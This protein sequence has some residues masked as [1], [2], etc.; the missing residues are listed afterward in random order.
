M[1]HRLEHVLLLMPQMQ[2]VLLYGI[3]FQAPVADTQV[4][5][6]DRRLVHSQLSRTSH[7]SDGFYVTVLILIDL[8]D[9]R[10]G[11]DKAYREPQKQLLPVRDLPVQQRPAHAF[12]Q[13]RQRVA[14]DHPFPVGRGDPLRHVIEDPGQVEQHPQRDVHHVGQVLH[15]HAV[16]QKPAGAPEGEGQERGRRRHRVQ[17][18][19]CE[20]HVPRQHHGRHD[21]EGHQHLEAVHPYLCQHQDVLG[22]VYLRHDRF[23]VLDDPHAVLQHPVKEVPH[24]DA[25]EDEHREVRLLRP[26]H[27]P[28]H[29]RVDQHEAER[30]QHPPQPVEVRVRHLRAQLGA[31][32]DD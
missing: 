7:V 6:L 8:A 20:L 21:P 14:A 27:V 19:P 17:D 10:P 18:V 13:K 32:G 16:M 9:P 4:P 29:E 28:E 25:D 23:V 5:H 22:K 26:E 30:L 2:Q 1:L 3:G 24:G 11:Q 12:Q 15:E 31:R